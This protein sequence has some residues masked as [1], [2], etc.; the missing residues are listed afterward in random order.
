M[1]D[2]GQR[3]FGWEA[4][5]RLIEVH[6]FAHATD[7]APG[8]FRRVVDSQ[9]A[10]TVSFDSWDEKTGGGY[11]ASFSLGVARRDIN[12]LWREL[13]QPG[14][15]SWWPTVKE[16]VPPGFFDD[17]RPAGGMGDLTWDGGPRTYTKDEVIDWVDTYVPRLVEA[18]T[19][20][21][22]VREHLVKYKTGKN[23]DE[24]RIPRMMDALL[25]GRWDDLAEAELLGRLRLRVEKNPPSTQGHIVAVRQLAAV[26]AWLAKNPDGVERELVD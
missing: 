2:P 15:S 14:W 13:L 23:V 25:D 21:S 20:L 18:A 6:G 7:I 4:A 12:E 17:G 3:D 1:L 24:T 26:E 5:N 16:R 10:A 22:F 8:Q 9:H 19:S 11:N